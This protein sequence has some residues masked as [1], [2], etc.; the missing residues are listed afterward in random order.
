MTSSLYHISRRDSA[1][2]LG[3]IIAHFIGE[4]RQEALNSWRM[5]FMVSF[6]H[7][8]CQIN[9]LELSNKQFDLSNRKIDLSNRKNL[10]K[11][12]KSAP[13]SPFLFGGLEKI[14]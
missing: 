14:L 5:F 7:P 4:Y 9:N 2:S 10:A 6:R 3:L 8:T 12:Y 1:W 11:S 13:R